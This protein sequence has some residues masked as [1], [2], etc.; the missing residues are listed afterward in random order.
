MP[1]PMTTGT[2][3]PSAAPTES[4]T[5]GDSSCWPRRS[6]D[7]LRSLVTWQ[8]V[9]FRDDAAADRELESA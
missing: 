8:T 2:T 1:G 3:P 9:R 7:A 6:V 4:A 5:A